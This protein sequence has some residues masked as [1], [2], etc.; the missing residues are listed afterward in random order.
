[1]RSSP[2]TLS[3]SLTTVLGAP[4]AAALET[5]FGITTVRELLWTRPRRLMENGQLSDLSD[6]PDGDFITVSAT[7][8]SVSDRPMRAKKGWLVEVAIQGENGHSL[9]LTFFD[10]APWRKKTIE[11]GEVGIFSGTVSTYQGRRQLVYPDYVLFPREGGPARGSKSASSMFGH[12]DVLHLPLIPIYPATRAVGSFVVADSIWLALSYLDDA[13]DPMPAYLRERHE[14]MG[15]QDAL[16]A[17]HRPR[18][19]A[20]ASLGAKRLAWDEALGLQVALARR[21]AAARLTPAKARPSVAGGILDAFDQNL[22]FQLTAGQSEISTLIADELS[23][24]APMQRL[25]QGEVGSG[26]TVVALRAMLQVV[27]AGGQAALLAPTEVLAAQHIRTIDA[28]MGDLAHQGHLGGAERGTRVTLLTG[29]QGAAARRIALLEAA[30]GS[31]GIVVGTHA[32]IQEN[33]QFAELALV[34][35]DEQHRFGVEQRDALRAKATTPPH[36]LVMTATPIPRTVAMTVFGDLDTS[37]LR[38][39][40]AGRAGISTTVVPAAE[41]PAWLDRAWTRV[42]EE[43]SLGHQVYVVCPRIGLAEGDDS[44][45]DGVASDRRAPIAVIDLAAELSAGALTGA[46]IGVLH[47]RLGGEQKEAVMSAFTAGDIDVLIAT[48]VIEV[49]VDVPNA[50]TMVV[51]DADRFGVSQL[52]QLRGRIGRGGLPGLCLLITEAPPGSAARER[53]DAV[54]ATTDG[55]ALARLDLEQRRE[56]NVL[57]AAQSGRTTTLRFLSV[58]KDEEVIAQARQEAIA[59]VADDPTLSSTPD[60][61]RHLEAIIGDEHADYLEKS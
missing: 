31:A 60:L 57:G 55:F 45:E 29:S 21:R 27:D 34:V 8:H 1:M 35:V 16:R 9:R 41:K 7:V 30:S 58:L 33:V 39:L 15:F 48:T 24:T 36:L 40:P 47:G 20:H 42:L 61:A 6:S 11:P 56:G 26:K 37:T 18:S 46:R 4:T 17:V 32:V 2:I 54:A 50:T 10:R 22:P 38:E 23:G 12:E 44:A 43:V 25:L 51:M 28:L 14:L 59:L 52:H 53:V 13:L 3:T 19:Y 5:A 49:G